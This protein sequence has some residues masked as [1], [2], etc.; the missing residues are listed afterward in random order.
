MTCN[1]SSKRQKAID[2]KWVFSV[3]TGTNNGNIPR[4]KVRLC[5]KGY[6]QKKR[7]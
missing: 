4:F 5:A 7:Y 1:H 2:S 3:K 6:A